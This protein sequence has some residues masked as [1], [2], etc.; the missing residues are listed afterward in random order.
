MAPFRRETYM[1]CIFAILVFTASKRP[2]RGSGE[3]PKEPETAFEAPKTPQRGAQEGPNK[4]PRA[5]KSAPRALHEGPKK[6]I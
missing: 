4:A 5:P 6:P 1:F 3:A 2:K